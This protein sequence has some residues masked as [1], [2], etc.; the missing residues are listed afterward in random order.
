M[1]I[2]VKKRGNRTEITNTCQGNVFP[3]DSSGQKQYLYFYSTTYG[4]VAIL[5][6]SG[7][8]AASDSSIREFS[9]ISLKAAS[10]DRP[11]PC[12]RQAIQCEELSPD[13]EDMLL[14]HTID[15][16]QHVFE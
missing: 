4:E 7:L 11:E 15:M 1:R 9:S 14:F 3:V 10:S 13:V 12:D 5:S 16:S 6:P 8:S 2:V